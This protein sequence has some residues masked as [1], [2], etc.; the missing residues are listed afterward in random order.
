[1]GGTNKR[2]QAISSNVGVGF[3]PILQAQN[4][5]PFPKGGKRNYL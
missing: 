5:L 1:M 4:P 3:I 2:E